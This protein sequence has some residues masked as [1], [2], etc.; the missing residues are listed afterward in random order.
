MSSYY[1]T[2]MER[3]N[4]LPMK[5]KLHHDAVHQHVSLGGGLTDYLKHFLEDLVL[6]L[7][8]LDPSSHVLWLPHGSLMAPPCPC[9]AIPCQD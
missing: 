3:L 9:P 8:L 2:K 6:D 4:Q 5:K 1:I 7:H